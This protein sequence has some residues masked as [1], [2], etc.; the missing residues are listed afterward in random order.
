MDRELAR[1]GHRFVRYA[2]DCNVYVRSKR[3]GQRVKQGLTRFLTERL[4]L[5]VNEEKSAVDRPWK[6]KFLGF[7]FTA[8]KEPKRRIAPKALERLKERVW[9]LTCRSTGRS[10]EQIIERLALHLTGWR[11]YFGFCETPSVLANLDSWIRRR[12]RCVAWKHWKTGSARLAELRRRGVGND[13]ARQTAG[14]GLGPWHIGKS[15]ALSYALPNAFF[16]SLGLPT[17]APR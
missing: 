17:L 2:D 5:K 1:R 9:E 8:A 6:R 14:S 4:K 7:S 3:A 13:L 15:P 12:L 10:L 16:S 11:G